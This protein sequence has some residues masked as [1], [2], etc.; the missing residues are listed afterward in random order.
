MYVAELSDGN[1]L[2]IITNYT[3]NI[4]DASVQ[5]LR[6]GKIWTSD[7][8]QDYPEIETVF[9]REYW[10]AGGCGKRVGITPH[11]V[12]E[13]AIREYWSGSTDTD[14]AVYPVADR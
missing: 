4:A 12:F 9:P 6:D 7:S 8:P 3:N 11:P 13:Q 1:E 2:H 14:G 5:L 10:Y